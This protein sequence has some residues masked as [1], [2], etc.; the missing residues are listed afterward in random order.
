MKGFIKLDRA[1][2]D[3]DEW[4][5]PRRFSKAE[6]ML[7]I[8]RRAQVYDNGVYKVGTVKLTVRKAAELWGWNKDAVHRFIRSLIKDGVISSTGT[9]SIYAIGCDT[10]SDKKRDTKKRIKPNVSDDGCDTQS[11]IKRETDDFTPIYNKKERKEKTRAREDG[12][13]SHDANEAMRKRYDKFTQWAAENIPNLNGEINI[14]I[15]GMMYGQAFHN[16]RKM[17]DV[18]KAMEDDGFTG[19]KR[20]MMKEF[21]RRCPR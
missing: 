4:K 3:S 13:I 10:Q 9:A 16:T 14:G 21:E 12:N 11:D 5:T 1:F 2:F 17:A 15:F 19:D 6:A 7:D 20:Q 8:L 18:L